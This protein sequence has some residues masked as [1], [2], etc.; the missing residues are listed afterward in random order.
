M[1]K[2][3][4]RTQVHFPYLNLRGQVQVRSVHQDINSSEEVVITHPTRNLSPLSVSQTASLPGR[5][6][7]SLN[8]GDEFNRI[9]KLLV[10]FH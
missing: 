10:L 9:L 8:L 1:A 7:I 3:V 6:Q 4:T 2:N 5:T